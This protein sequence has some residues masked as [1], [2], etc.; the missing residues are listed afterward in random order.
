MDN[1]DD[2]IPMTPE[3]IAEMNDRIRLAARDAQQRTQA[4]II[5]RSNQQAN[6]IK[7]DINR[8]PPPND[9]AGPKSKFWGNPDPRDPPSGSAPVVQGGKTRRRYK[10]KSR[11]GYKKKSRRGYKK[12]RRGRK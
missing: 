2:D 3:E 9:E 5:M 6:I 7:K 10:K 8:L 11:G 1:D 12:S 4:Q